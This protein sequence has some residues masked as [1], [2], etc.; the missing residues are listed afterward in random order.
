MI[1]IILGAVGGQGLVLTTNLICQAAFKAGYDVKSNDVVGLSQRGGKVWGSVR[2][3]KKV[4][5]PNVLAGMGDFLLGME[6][7]EGY[8]LSHQI[9]EGG[10]IILNTKQQA[11]VH[12]MFE[13]MEYPV[14]LYDKLNEK[15]KV[16]TIDANEAGIKL[17]SVKVAN[18]FLIGILAKHLDIETQYWKE[19]IAENVPQ[20]FIEMNYKAFDEG[21]AY[22]S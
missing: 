12:V 21:Y 16:I 20:K 1:N 15:Y 10:T 8:R 17:G 5:S 19:A 7:L 11:P 18:T 9:K 22:K 3:G 13:A 2:I 14:D 4:H 6:P